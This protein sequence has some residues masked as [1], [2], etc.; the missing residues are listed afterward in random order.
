MDP[1]EFNPNFG[2]VRCDTGRGLQLTAHAPE[3]HGNSDA[4]PRCIG[5]TYFYDPSLEF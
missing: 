5:P 4:A 1:S 3:F 2:A